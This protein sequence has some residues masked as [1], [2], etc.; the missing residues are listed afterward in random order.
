MNIFD[1]IDENLFRP[2]TGTNKRKYVD[3]LT[4]IWNKCKRMPMYAIEKSTIFDMVEEYFCGLDEQ[5]ELDAEEQK[6]TEGNF[7]DARAIA[8][9]FVRRLRDTG[10]ITEKDG[11]Y[12]EE[13]R[14]A[15]NYKVVPIIKSFQEIISPT[16]I[17][18]KG[19]LFK[20]YSMFEHIS[21]QGS[22]Y[23]GVLKE[24]SDDFDNFNQALRTLAASIEDHI[25][26]LTQGKKPEEVLDFF[27]KYEEKIVVGSYHRFKTNDNLFYYRT[28]LYES[29]DKC[30]DILFDA[31]VS[32]YM[33]AE[34]VEQAEAT[35]KIKQ[36]IVK[37]RMDIEEM[38]AIMR[39]ID[40]RH[41]IYRT[42]AVQ[43]AQFLL[44]SDGS[45]KSKINN[46][47]QYYA[48]KITSKEDLYGDDE[49][50]C[51]DVFQIFGQNFLDCASLAIPVKKRRST[52][53]ELMAVVDE[54]DMDLVEEKKR[55]M[56]EYIK[57]ALTSENVNGFAKDILKG[58]TAVSVRSIFENSPENLIKIIGLYTY[59]KTSE[60]KY[61]I[62]LK[63]N[64]V[65]SNGIR[66]KE[67]I[68]EERKGQS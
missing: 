32:D 19:K 45:V 18:Y 4:L 36:L 12:E 10:W 47:L 37:V 44:L 38:E 33:E 42:R 57:N 39:T 31:L 3:I 56:S 55:K 53:I 23:E 7:T 46:L 50:C 51:S 25:N 24:A 20:I 29:L 66:F 8:G 21:D 41:I 13:S 43:R 68:V 6:E 9:G 40:D 60:R 34:R 35:Y 2:L 48:S 11:E 26:N 16:I 5:V 52:P 65:E 49:T 61:E 64:Y 15:I 54:L 67:F 22:P 59:S 27:E 62:R 30:E 28:S 1:E 63:D 14:L 58:K 17:T